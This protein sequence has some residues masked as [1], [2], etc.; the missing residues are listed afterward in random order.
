[1]RSEEAETKRK[2]GK[3]TSMFRQARQQ[4]V[5]TKPKGRVGDIVRKKELHGE[6]EART[7]NRYRAWG[8]L[9][10]LVVTQGHNV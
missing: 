9:G 1:M 8:E 7:A 10:K 2:P 4:S 5:D 6:S 3:W